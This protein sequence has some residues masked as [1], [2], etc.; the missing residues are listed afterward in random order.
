M[1]IDAI[2]KFME[3]LSRLLVKGTDLATKDGRQKQKLLGDM[4]VLDKQIKAITEKC[5]EQ[6]EKIFAMLKNKEFD[7]SQEQIEG[8]DPWPARDSLGARVMVTRPMK[9]ADIE[10]FRNNAWMK[11][12]LEAYK[13]IK[14]QVDA[15]VEF[16]K[17]KMPEQFAKA[18]AL[19]KGI[20]N[21]TGIDADFE[22]GLMRDATT[23]ELL[24]DV[25]GNY[26]YHEVNPFTGLTATPGDPSVTDSV[27]SRFFGNV[28]NKVI[29]S[30]DNIKGYIETDTSTTPHIKKLIDPVTGNQIHGVKLNDGTGRIVDPVDYIENGTNATISAGFRGATSN[31][32]AGDLIMD[33]LIAKKV[34]AFIAAK[35]KIYEGMSKY[36]SLVLGGLDKVGEKDTAINF[37]LLNI[38]A[39]SIDDLQPAEQSKIREQAQREV[40]AEFQNSMIPNLENEAMKRTAV[41]YATQMD[42]KGVLAGGSDDDKIAAM[43]VTY[44]IQAEANKIAMEMTLESG[45]LENYFAGAKHMLDTIYEQKM[46]MIFQEVKDVVQDAVGVIEFGDPLAIPPTMDKRKCNS[47]EAVNLAIKDK[48]SGY[49][50]TNPVLYHAVLDRIEGREEGFEKM[51]AGWEYDQDVK[52]GTNVHIAKFE[53]SF[54]DAK[55]LTPDV[56]G[57]RSKFPITE[58]DSAGN[59]KTLPRTVNDI[60]N[61]VC[62]QLRRVNNGIVACTMMEINPDTGEIRL[63]EDLVNTFNFTS[64]EVI[65]TDFGPVGGSQ[66]LICKD[67]FRGITGESLG[68]EIDAQID[69]QE[70]K[71][72]DNKKIEDVHDRDRKR[73]E[74]AQSKD[75]YENWKMLRA[76]H[77]IYKERW[78][79][80]AKKL[81]GNRQSMG[82]FLQSA[83]IFKGN[84][85]EQMSEEE[86]DVYLSEQESTGMEFIDELFLTVVEYSM[87]DEDEEQ[88]ELTFKQEAHEILNDSKTNYADKKQDIKDT[89]KK[90]LLKQEA[91]HLTKILYEFRAFEGKVYTASGHTLPDHAVRHIATQIMD[92]TESNKSFDDL[93][94]NTL[95]TS[96]PRLFD[97]YDAPPSDP[98][99]KKIDLEE[100][101]MNVKD[102][103]KDMSKDIGNSSLVKILEGELEIAQDHYTNPH[104]SYPVTLSINGKNIICHDERNVDKC[105]KFI[106][107][108]IEKNKGKLGVELDEAMQAIEEL[109]RV[110]AKAGEIDSD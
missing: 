106:E 35:Q 95:F 3:A 70:K 98:N 24:K 73:G 78:L 107:T 108:T 93:K 81:L 6:E 56:P 85:I 59:T 10:L 62:E 105:I 99:R 67:T 18:E 82:V 17:D 11:A 25:D 14:G 4:K 19:W 80:F 75:S 23:N 47:S 89:Y 76:L 5:K 1:P 86:M 97:L 90:H 69:A 38:G 26:I 29:R 91:M 40:D 37:Q 94:H 31:I 104:T 34:E 42:D 61:G 50:K 58:R 53:D 60:F 88:K 33:K 46:S 41:N 96:N 68:P 52:N 44:P 110:H 8:T 55:F 15:M 30:R 32:D 74:K 39:S 63:N 54:A 109:R 72:R 100:I 45:G 36:F 7:P 102:R 28:I 77:E 92:Y 57:W 22:T 103:Q 20:A 79:A 64:G 43:L 9:E 16:A 71:Q 48:I 13:A 101:F 66:S 12:D 2:K 27:G 65:E 83:K 21:Q 51:W 84:N 87:E 49:K